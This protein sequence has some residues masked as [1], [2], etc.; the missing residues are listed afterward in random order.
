MALGKKRKGKNVGQSI[1]LRR[2]FIYV[3]SDRRVPNFPRLIS[4]IVGDALSP[5]CFAV[6]LVF[7]S[8]C[9]TCNYLILND[10][11]SANW[12]NKSCRN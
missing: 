6:L 1:N 2:S 11:L 4:F 7:P 5:L 9:S 12:V 8:T 10:L 3:F